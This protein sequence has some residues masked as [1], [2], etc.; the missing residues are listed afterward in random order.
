MYNEAF[1]TFP[2][3]ETDRLYLRRHQ[4]EDAKYIEEYLDDPEIEKFYDGFVPSGHVSEVIDAWCGEA[5]ASKTFI[6]WC[7]ARKEDN[8]CIGGIYLFLPYGDDI[9][10]RRMDIGYELSSTYRNKGYVSEAIKRITQYG[11]EN[12]GLKRVQAQ[13]IP[14][15]IASIRACEKAGFQ[16]EGLL[17]N[18]CHF[19]Q[20]GQCLRSMVMMSCIPSDIEY[21]Q[22]ID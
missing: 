10:G 7:I 18:F 14:E 17:R 2:N 16:Y 11:F 20:N 4:Q 8:R 22:A 21:A 13:I 1:T 6:R 5:Y 19:Q 12:M 9:A 15:N 3:L